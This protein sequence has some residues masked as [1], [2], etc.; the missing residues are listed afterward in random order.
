MRDE[1]DR[2]I[3][4]ERPRLASAAGNED[5][6]QRLQTLD[7]KS[8]NYATRRDSPDSGSSVTHFCLSDGAVR[9]SLE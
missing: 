9:P 1:L 3:R 8:S 2:L 5:A 6:K 4:E 7:A